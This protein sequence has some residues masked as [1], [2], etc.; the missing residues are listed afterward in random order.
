MKKKSAGWGF[1]GPWTWWNAHNDL[2]EERLAHA[3]RLWADGIAVNLAG[4]THHVFPD[5]GAEFCVLNDAAIAARAM[6]IE[7]GIR[8]IVIIDGDVHQGDG[9]AAIFANDP[10]VRFRYT[11]RGI[12]PFENSRAIWILNWLMV[13]KMTSTW[14]PGAPV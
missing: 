14:L 3:E 2:W 1:H 9:T 10:S 11:A 4:G 13:Q 12:S 6:Q 7:D 8:Q 5:H